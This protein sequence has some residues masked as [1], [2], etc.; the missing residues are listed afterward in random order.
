MKHEIPTIY[1]N[2]LIYKPEAMFGIKDPQFLPKVATKASEFIMQMGSAETMFNYT[3]ATLEKYLKHGFATFATDEENNI[4][5]FT[6]MDPWCYY[7]ETEKVVHGKDVN[8][9]DIEHGLVHILGYESGSLVVHGDHQKNGLAGEM[10][11]ELIT[12]ISLNKPKAP[13]FAICNY[14]NGPPQKVYEKL[15][16]DPSCTPKQ[17]VEL[18]GT[19]V[20]EVEDWSQ[21]I[22]VQ[23]YLYQPSVNN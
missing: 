6:K 23:I 18:L 12:S 3:P 20:F 13:I 7:P 16:W 21:E 1:S 10:V 11:K 9:D 14:K 22:P 15:N 2:Y 19:D 17:L 4:V 8:F 5:G